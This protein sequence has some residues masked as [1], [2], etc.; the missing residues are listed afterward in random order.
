[1]DNDNRLVGF[2]FLRGVAAFGIVGCHLMLSPRTQ[3]STLIT[4]LC[5]VNVGLFA[6]LSGY[7]MVCGRWDCWSGYVIKRARRI[8]P[9]YLAWTVVYLVL[10]AIF[11][12]LDGGV[13]NARYGNSRWWLNVVFWGSSSAHLWFLVSLLYAQV[14]MAGLFRNISGTIWMGC[15]LCI[16]LISIWANNW[17]V[18]YPIRLLAFLMLGR[19]L[20]SFYGVWLKR[21][22]A[23]LL[24]IG[25]ICMG[26]HFVPFPYPTG[27]VRDW[28]S[29]ASILLAFAAWSDWFSGRW[30]GIAK[31]LGVTS[32]G[33][34]LIHPIFTKGVGIAVRHIFSVPYGIVP[35]VT[36][37]CV[38]WLCALIVSVV[39]LRSVKMSWLVR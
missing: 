36:D 25:L 17:Y 37:W 8:L 10:S 28:F 19:G 20:V 9:I 5:D 24:V 14:A 35:V 33:V 29:V 11:Q 31:F 38:S 16:V 2:D 15:S 7:V 13:V 12:V 27:F 39:L 4:G 1:M 18:I 26:L 21:C 3:L 30:A 22:R 23:K 6:A 32:M 34:Y